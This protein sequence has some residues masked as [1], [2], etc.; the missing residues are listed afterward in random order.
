MYAEEWSHPGRTIF[1]NNC[2]VCHSFDD[3]IIGPPLNQITGLKPDEWTR[4]MI[5]NGHKLM[6]AGDTYAL[7]QYE[8]FGRVAHPDFEYL[9]EKE[10]SQLIEYLKLET[11]K[12]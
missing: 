1:S 3:T 8:V 5:R 7:K 6:Q 9:S 2:M 4:Q 12:N 10:I 11:K